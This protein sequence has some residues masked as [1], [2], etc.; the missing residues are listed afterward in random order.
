MK[1]FYRKLICC[2]IC[3]FST[4]VFPHSVPAATLYVDS[5]VAGPGTGTIGDPFKNIQDAIDVGT[6]NEIQVAGG[7]YPGSLELVAGTQLLG[8]YASG[9]GS[10]DIDANETTIDCQNAMRAILAVGGVEGFL[11]EGFSIV[12]ATAYAGLVG[13]ENGGGI[14]LLTDDVLA[15]S[16][17]VSDCLFLNCRADSGGGIAMEGDNI[18]L[19]VSQCEF[20]DC[21]ADDDAGAIKF[22]NGDS[23]LTVD[24]CLIVNC[25]GGDDGGA[26]KAGDSSGPDVTISNSVFFNNSGGDESVIE[27]RF[28]TRIL[29]CTFVNNSAPEGDAIIVERTND[30]NAPI[31]VLELVNNIF[32][33]NS[34]PMGTVFLVREDLLHGSVTVTNNLVFNNTTDGG[35][36][37]ALDGRLTGNG[38]FMD[39]PIFVNPF[40]LDFRLLVGSP[41]VDA[42][43]D[44]S[45]TVTEDYLG[46]S[47]PE[48]SAFDIG[49]HEGATPIPVPSSSIES[50]TLYN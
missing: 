39:D 13:E 37:F 31:A 40:A 48:G 9:F 4:L 42:G 41:A 20:R 21:S 49:A 22:D 11:V 17:T 24:R 1:M 32:V 36:G 34:A 47:R 35:P 23:F 15:V 12:N 28:I 19:V 44:L 30:D 5:S 27:G 25:E 46:N 3:V 2:V 14:R 33:G 45:A 7:V 38:N 10:R 26:I 18:N 8:G 50:W 6:N 16:G 43:A 29:N